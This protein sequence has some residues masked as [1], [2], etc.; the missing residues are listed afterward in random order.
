MGDY[1]SF[2][3]VGPNGKACSGNDT[4]WVP[5]QVIS[6]FHAVPL[7]PSTCSGHQ[8]FSII[9]DTKVFSL[10]PVIKS[11]YS[12]R[13]ISLQQALVGNPPPFCQP[14]AYSSPTKTFN[15]H[16]FTNVDVFLWVSSL[17]FIHF[18]KFIWY[19]L[20]WQLSSPPCPFKFKSKIITGKYLNFYFQ[21]AWLAALSP[22]VSLILFLYITWTLWVKI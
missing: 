15:D 21:Q 5:V 6:F 4:S 7:G 17:T 2:H 1:I 18:S 13:P 3:P 12:D 9:T 22:S 20:G 10:Y 11:N 19:R 8:Q 16:K 14:L